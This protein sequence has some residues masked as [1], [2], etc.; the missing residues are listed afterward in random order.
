ME[1]NGKQM[2]AELLD[3]DKARKLYEDIVRKSLDPALLEYAEQSLFKVRI[4]PIEPMKE[5]RIKITYS[6]VLESDNNTYEYIFPLNT[7]KY[8]AKPLN[9]V[10]IHVDMKSKDEI[11]TVYIPTHDAHIIRKDDYH[12]VVGYEAKE[13]KPD[14]DFKLY[15]SGGEDKLGMSLLTYKESSDDGFFCLNISPGIAVKSEEIV[16]K[17]ITFVLDVSGSMMGEKMEQAKKALL[18]CVNNL[19]RNDRFEIIRFSTEAEAL[20]KKR[21]VADT[22]NVRKAKDFI[23]NL[24]AIGGT[25][26]SEAFELALK[27][28]STP[29]R[30]HFIVFITDGKPTIGVLDEA[31]LL[32]QIMKLNGENTRIFTFGVGYDINT[33][34]LD[35]ITEQTKAYRTYIAPE[36]NIEAKISS[37]YSKISSPVLT[38]L[39]LEVD[40]VNFNKMVPKQLPDL[41]KG[42]SITILGRF[43][44]TGKATITLKGKL[45]QKE[46]KFEQTFELKEDT[47]HDFVA[48]LWAARYIGYLLDQIR[49]HGENAEL[50]DEVIQ[51][52]K[53]YGII[54]PYTS[55]LILE[56]EVVSV[57]RRGLTEE[58]VIFNGRAFDSDDFTKKNKAEFEN[59]NEN[60]GNMGVRSSSEVQ[61]LAQAENIDQTRQGMSR[62]AYKDVNGVEQNF[63]QQVR[64][65]QGRAFYQKADE[66]IDLYVQDN[67]Q[68]NS[69]KRI[70]FASNEYFNLLSSAPSTSQYLSLGRNVR[71][72]YNNTLYEVY[73]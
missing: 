24:K 47:Q 17:D 43:T 51:I 33:H 71:F 68:S 61:S 8:S 63:A 66:W 21:V 32:E 30:P 46:E 59:I 72:V 23:N 6:E 57:N 11:K 40:G 3:A 20:F 34:L 36:E 62:M 9:N 28:K 1:I 60:A 5:K 69:T 35:K 52:A 56:D 48:S 26:I 65:V 42:S 22:A 27:E 13:V 54:T 37:F 14:T 73:E 58:N 19:N 49:L 64:N 2:E 31:P 67:K 29:N 41:F 39:Q 44:G 70:Q 4:F 10:A 15:I 45:N 7:K 18:F 50:K 53:K 16:N 12:S 55:Y 38:D 25:H